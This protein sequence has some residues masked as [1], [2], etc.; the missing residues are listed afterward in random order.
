MGRA[1][2]AVA[3]QMS[4]LGGYYAGKPSK[5]VICITNFAPKIQKK[6]PQPKLRGFVAH[7]P[8]AV[9]TFD[10]IEM[11]PFENARSSASTPVRVI[12]ISASTEFEP[13][14]LVSMVTTVLLPD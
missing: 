9:G 14:A 1:A 13:K 10:Y 8:E 12:L 7:G 11:M 2:N 4:E 6:T 3:R 5:F